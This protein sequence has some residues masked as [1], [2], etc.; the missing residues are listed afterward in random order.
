MSKSVLATGVMRGSR[1]GVHVSLQ[2]TVGT[3]GASGLRPQDRKTVSLV[4]D[5]CESLDAEGVG[6]CH[7]KSTA[8]LE[9]SATAENDLDLLVDRAD[10]SRLGLIL[11]RLGFKEARDPRTAPGVADFYGYD[12]DA[13]RFVH[14]HVHYQLVVGDDATKNYRLPI[15]DAFLASA[16]SQGIFRVPS[17]ELEL[18]AFVIRMVLKHATWDALLTRQG[19]L[20]DRARQELEYLRAAADQDRLGSLLRAH[21]PSL[22]VTL[23]AD[24][25][26][27]LT[28][29]C[30]V[31]RRVR[32]GHRLLVRLKP[33]TRRPRFL[34]IGLKLWR[35][36]V[37]F[38][39]RR[40][41]R[42]PKLGAQLVSG[43]AMIAVVGGD[44][45]GKSTAVGQLEAW[46][47]RDFRA[48]RIHLGRPP[49]SAATFLI[50]TA[51]K[52]RMRLARG[53]GRYPKILRVLLDL[54]IARDRRS[55][56]SDAR[57]FANR[58]GLVICDRFP[59]RDVPSIDG[60]RL[61]G[62]LGAHE[63]KL[64][65]LLL[66]IEQRYFA[67]L[68][69]PDVLIALLVDPDIAVE[70]RPDER[71]DFV[72]QRC[73]EFSRVAWGSMR[74]HVI[75]AGRPPSEVLAVVKRSVW[76]SL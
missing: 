22:G 44:G 34:D 15:E 28:P 10:A 46:L 45:A 51:L 48:R 75:D 7:W 76:S 21:L 35:R 39:A 33:Y 6:Y 19:R 30:G 64:P 26:R 16:T 14:V 5:L 53:R 18:V 65:R 68:A 73:E 36:G 4:R 29:G 1:R 27:A 25:V 24:C 12:S 74:A 52:A 69:P 11:H 49:Q 40:L 57:R 8:F 43:G 66:A 62:R 2:E 17:P 60:P 3:G 55:A 47:S 50:R 63:G 32:T 61:P 67:G 23:F 56:Y 58:G 54:A 71:P 9:R 59:L 20:P 72:R 31:W 38:L 13:D 70:R 37:S 42:T 41:S